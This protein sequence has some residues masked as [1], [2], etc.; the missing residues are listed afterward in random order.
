MPSFS[1]GERR[2]QTPAKLCCLEQGLLMGIQYVYG[3]LC[4]PGCALA[5]FENLMTQ[6]PPYSPPSICIHSIAR[7]IQ[8]FFFF[9]RNISSPCRIPER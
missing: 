4:V 5:V 2:I 9:L 7:Q 6:I 1:F 3:H 8:Y